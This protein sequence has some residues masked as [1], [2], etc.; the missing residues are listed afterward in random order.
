MN[1]REAG[2]LNNAGGPYFPE[3][4]KLVMIADRETPEVSQITNQIEKLVTG[5]LAG[6]NFSVALFVADKISETDRKL[7]AEDG[8]N[9][10]ELPVSFLFTERGTG[11][12]VVFKENRLFTE[13]DILMLT[14]SPA[15]M[16]LQNLLSDNSNYNVVVMIQG[17]NKDANT[18]VENEIA[19]AIKECAPRLGKQE[20]KLLKVD[21]SDKAEKEFLREL[22]VEASA[23]PVCAVVFGKGRI[24]VPLLK[25]NDITSATLINMLTFVQANASDCTPDAVYLPGSVIDMIMPWN[26]KL[27]ARVYEAIAK[28]GVVADLMWT[29][30]EVDR[31]TGELIDKPVVANTE[32][33]PAAVAPEKDPKTSS[34]FP[35]QFRTT[36]IIITGAGVIGIIIAWF[37]LMRRK[38][39]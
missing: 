4:Y 18:K 14:T 2:F 13:E 26:E 29:E 20:I 15:R 34:S 5:T 12:F 7:M 22:G 16:S 23:E 19:A 36:I 17:T 38:S 33:A 3:Q 35:A 31:N 1:V 10:G 28:S 9:L 39:I 30:A 37:A 11:R 21:K 6:C 8:I 24:V 27:D 32:T 25:G